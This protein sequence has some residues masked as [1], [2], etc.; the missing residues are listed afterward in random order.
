[1]INGI[2]STEFGDSFHPTAHG[3]AIAGQELADAI[4][5]NVG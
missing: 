3:A 1:M 5:R 4:A 2:A